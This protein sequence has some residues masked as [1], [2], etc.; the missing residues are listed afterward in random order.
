MGI[1][2]DRQA[3]LSTYLKRHRSRRH[4]RRGPTPTRRFSRT[5]NRVLVGSEGHA[6]LGSGVGANGDLPSSSLRSTGR[7][8]RCNP[9]SPE[10]I[11]GRR[12][13]IHP[14]GDL[15][16]SPTG[17]GSAD[18][19]KRAKTNHYQA[20]GAF[21]PESCVVLRRRSLSGTQLSKVNALVLRGMLRRRA[22]SAGVNV[23]GNARYSRTVV[24]SE[25]D[26]ARI[27]R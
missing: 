5:L 3:S 9:G 25:H 2:K 8:T 20:Q 21:Y 15:R 27:A 18:A 10:P 1:G 23:V 6:C 13:G 24:L 26:D 16:A 17:R 7:A 4:A 22:M 14:R 11:S 12:A 19:S